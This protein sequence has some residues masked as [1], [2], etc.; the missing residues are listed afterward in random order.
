MDETLKTTMDVVERGTHSLRRANRS[1]NIPMS[2]LFD[3]LCGKIR[4]RKIGPRGVLT[5]EEGL[6]VITWTLAM[7]ECGL[8]ISLQQ[9][10]MKVVELT[11]TRFTLFQDGI[12]SNRWWFWFKCRH[13]KI[14]I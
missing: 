14:S 6:A 9:F 11:Y 13:L 10:K 3:H 5:K 8:S 7:Q 12:P 2:S 4:S 1:W